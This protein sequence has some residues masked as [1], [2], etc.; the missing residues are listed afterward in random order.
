MGGNL[1]SNTGKGYDTQEEAL[2]IIQDQ[3]ASPMRPEVLNA[4]SNKRVLE[5]YGLRKDLF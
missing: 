3:L 1:W 2:K 5:G 4:A